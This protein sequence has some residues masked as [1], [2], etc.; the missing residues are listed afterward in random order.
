VHALFICGKVRMRSPA[1]ATMVAALPLHA[2][3][4]RGK[5]VVTLGVPGGYTCNDACLTALL[6]PKREAG[7]R[8]D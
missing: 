6:L 1:A 7:L 2:A 8:R 3:Q 5:R 4:L